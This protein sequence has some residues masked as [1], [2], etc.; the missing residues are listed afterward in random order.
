MT[1]TEVQE[2]VGQHMDSILECFKPGCK[3]T[4][5]VRTPD[6]PDRD[7]M[8]TSDDPKEAIA[9]IERRIKP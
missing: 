1:L 9:M 3:I 5:L 2:T 6:H 7:F 4:V 8:L